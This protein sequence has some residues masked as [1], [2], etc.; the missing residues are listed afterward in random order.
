VDN[1]GSVLGH[2]DADMKDLISE[3]AK[4]QRVDAE[5]L[6][7]KAQSAE[8]GRITDKD[9]EASAQSL[10]DN[11]APLAKKIPELGDFEN[12]LQAERKSLENRLKRIDNEIGWAEDRKFIDHIDLQRDSLERS[13]GF[14]V[15]FNVPFLR[16][17]NENR[18]RDK[19]L[20]AADERRA[21]R[22][23]KEAGGILRR[24]R[25]ELYSLAAQ[26]E[27]MRA[28]LNKTRALA[29]RTKGVNDIEL[30]AV[31]G[32]FG[33]ELERDVI[34]QAIK[35]YEAYLEL[36]RDTGSFARFSGSDLLDPKWRAFTK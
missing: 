15:A 7:V 22:E 11:V 33:F 23:K 19:A 3:M 34:I 21:E 27:S 26:V 32:D 1:N 17:D 35:F 24:K 30:K 13:D 36:L 16:F 5:H 2:P 18:A 31:L 9:I 8:L 12:T 6:G 29:R 4:L 14:R 20:L 10:I 25:A 28:R